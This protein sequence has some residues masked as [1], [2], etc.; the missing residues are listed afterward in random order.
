MNK[1]LIL[2]C[3]VNASLSTT[4]FSLEI[5]DHDKAKLIGYIDTYTEYLN[6]HMGGSC[7][8]PLIKALNKK[9]YRYASK[10]IDKLAVLKQE[11]EDDELSCEQALVAITDKLAPYQEPNGRH[12]LRHARFRLIKAI[13]ETRSLQENDVVG[14]VKRT[15]CI[16]LEDDKA[17]FIV[18]NCGHAN[19]CR[20]CERHA[21][22]DTC[23]TCREEIDHRCKNRICLLCG[24]NPA[25]TL[26][27][28]CDH[29]DTCEACLPERKHHSCLVCGSHSR[30][31]TIKLFY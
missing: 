11:I 30:Y 26:H 28:G 9:K 24:N 16:C 19:V 25:T 14:K 21:D 8:L 12:F 20:S 7:C 2:F 27:R 10:K 4:G 29:L 15:C 5:G 22:L 18:Y 3:L 1:P 6:D 31:Q 23:P 17:D 13:Y